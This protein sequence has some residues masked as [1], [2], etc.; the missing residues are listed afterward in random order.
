MINKTG[1]FL[2][3][4]HRYLTPLFIAVT[5]WFMLINKNPELG[6]VLGKV[7]KVMMLTLAVTGAFLFF[8]IYFNKYKARKKK[9]MA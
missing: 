1:K 6:L 8:Q 7:Q 9:A 2:R 3:K 4:L 5:V